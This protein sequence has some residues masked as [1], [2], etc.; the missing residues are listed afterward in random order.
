MIKNV[1]SNIRGVYKCNFSSL[2][3][4]CVFSRALVNS[5]L[6]S[7]RQAIGT[8][9]RTNLKFLARLGKTPSEALNMLQQVYRDETMSCSRVFEWHTIFKEGRKDMKDDPRS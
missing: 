9:Q 6:I 8:E 4:L 3:P 1:I 2:Q 5:S 7:D